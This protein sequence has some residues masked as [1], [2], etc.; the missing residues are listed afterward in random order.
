[1]NGKQFAIVAV[2]TFVVGM[3]W[4]ISDII[5]NT[6]ASIT[7]SDK[8]QVLLEPVN[9]TFNSRVLDMIGEETLNTDSIIIS[10][11]PS[12]SSSPS[13]S[14]EPAT[15]LDTAP[16][17]ASAFPVPTPSPLAV[18]PAPSIAAPVLPEAAA[19]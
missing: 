5:F 3:I 9:P 15:D 1:M 7:I 4:L 8:L 14:V 16:P 10:A 13:P 2:I 19:Q 17:A 6:K 18:S 12:P 11:P